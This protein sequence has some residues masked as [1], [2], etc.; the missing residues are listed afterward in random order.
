MTPATFLKNALHLRITPSLRTLAPRRQ[1]LAKLQERFGDVLVYK[2]LCVRPAIHTPW[3]PA[4]RAQYDK[5]LPR[6]SA[7][8]ALLIFRNT[9]SFRRLRVAGDVRVA[10]DDAPFDPHAL[11]WARHPD[12]PARRRPLGSAAD[13]LGDLR[14]MAPAQPHE[15]GELRKIARGAPSPHGELAAALVTKEQIAGEGG[16]GDSQPPRPTFEVTVR[17]SRWQGN[18]ERYLEHT[19]FWG[20]FRVDAS[21]MQAHLA[22]LGGGGVPMFGLSDIGVQRP[23]KPE[24]LVKERKAEMMREPTLLELWETKI[25][26]GGVDLDGEATAEGDDPVSLAENNGPAMKV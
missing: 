4:N 10:I 13:P 18:H 2:S 15:L 14:R 12:A 16:E 8:A 26:D 23:S 21:M 3:H 9:D 25:L 22:R 19:P 5:N 17:A 1:L 11:H 7:P 20:K 24:F 6:E